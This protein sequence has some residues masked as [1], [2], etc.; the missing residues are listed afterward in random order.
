MLSRRQ[1]ITQAG[2]TIAGFSIA[3]CTSP[4]NNL[5]GGV[6]GMMLGYS[7]I[8]WGGNDVQAIKDISQ[9][10]FK[11]VQLRSNIMREYGSKPEVIRALLQENQ[12]ELPMFSSGNANIDTCD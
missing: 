1:F 9:L 6:P 8:T 7:A 4:V 11:G 3:S 2:I 5:A 12:L 10:G